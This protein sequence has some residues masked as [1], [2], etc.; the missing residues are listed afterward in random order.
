MK[1][2]E[3]F[4]LNQQL[5]D[6]LRQGIPLEGALKKLCA[7]LERGRWRS[8]FNELRQ[9]L[10]S[11]VPLD[12]AIQARNF[13]SLY[14]QLLR[15]GARTQ[16]FPAVLTL[17]ADYYH[18]THQLWTRLKGLMTYPVLLIFGSFF[19]SLWFAMLH[20]SLWAEKVE[21]PGP[22]F[23]MVTIVPPAAAA[24]ARAQPAAPPAKPFLEFETKDR[25]LLRVWM[26][27]WMPPTALLALVILLTCMLT[28]PAWRRTLRWQLPGFREGSLSHF[29]ASMSLLL[30]SGTPLPEALTLIG[31]LEGKTPLAREIKRWRQRAEEG[32]KHFADIAA[33]GKLLPPLFLW[34]VA[35]ASENLVAGFDRA[36]EIYRDRAM[37]RSDLLLNAALPVSLALIG[38]MILSQVYPFMTSF[39]DF[40]SPV[41][42]F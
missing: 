20:Q 24:G 39:F 21:T 31:S 27:L 30:K 25:A 10:E 1:N 42:N 15:I 13:P 12:Q 36:A 8:E 3:F 33:G 40:L 29:A 32:H 16:D 23:K 18:Q 4:L 37:Y 35:S 34:L 17:L 5:A 7:G 26:N 2:E 11:G 38:L 14:S 9:A 6:M 41:F 28:I 19:L 22:L